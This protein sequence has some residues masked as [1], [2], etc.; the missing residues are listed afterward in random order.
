M[1]SVNPLDSY[2]SRR[3]KWPKKYK[4][5]LVAM[6]DNLDTF[7]EALNRGQ[8]PA[9]AKF[10]FIHPEPHGVLAIDQKGGGP[11]VKESRLYIYAEP[12]TDTVHL[13]TLGDKNSQSEDLEQC[14]EFMKEL[15]YSSVSALV[16][17]A[18]QTKEKTNVPQ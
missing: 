14:K 5:E 12:E 18:T 10:G 2:D 8:R 11:H 17:R 6:H 7:L 16:N 15:R 9:D 13:I 1:W 4:R 3:R